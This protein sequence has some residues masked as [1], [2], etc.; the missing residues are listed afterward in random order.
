[1]ARQTQGD[2]HQEQGG[3]EADPE[4]LVREAG[5]GARSRAPPILENQRHITLLKHQ[6]VAGLVNC[7]AAEKQK[8]T[9]HVLH[10]AIPGIPK[11]HATRTG[12]CI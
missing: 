12:F 10:G 5:L 4:G 3:R 11:H 8:E 2:D 9:K 1:M 6:T 7:L